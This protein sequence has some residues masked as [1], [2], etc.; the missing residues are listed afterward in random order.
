MWRG[1]EGQSEAERAYRA[2]AR[3]ARL[4]GVTGRRHDTPYEYAALLAREVPQ[5]EEQIRCIVNSY[6][7]QHFSP[8]RMGREE[9]DAMRR[10]WRS[11]RRVM[12]GSVLSRLPGSLQ[13][14]LQR[15]AVRL[16]PGRL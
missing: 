1:S 9:E 13:D 12:L 14:T 7:Q 11:L 16:R 8:H 2:M 6:V 5:G 3:Y 10:A 4:L 15:S